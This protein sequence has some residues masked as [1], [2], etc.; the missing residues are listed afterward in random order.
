MLTPYVLET[1]INSPRRWALHADFIIKSP[2][3]TDKLSKLSKHVAKKLWD[4]GF[5][6]VTSFYCYLMICDPY[7]PLNFCLVFVFFHG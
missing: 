7:T 6:Y 5:F 2:K 1:I 4:L 3:E